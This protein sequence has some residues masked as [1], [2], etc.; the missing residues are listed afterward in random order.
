MPHD[1]QEFTP[2]ERAKLTGLY[3]WEFDPPVKIVTSNFVQESLWRLCEVRRPLSP[4]PFVFIESYLRVRGLFDHEEVGLAYRLLHE[5]KLIDT[6]EFHSLGEHVLLPRLEYLGLWRDNDRLMFVSL[7][8]DREWEWLDTCD[9]VEEFEAEY[10]PLHEY[11]KW[12]GIAD[13]RELCVRRF[14][15]IDLSD[16]TVQLRRRAIRLAKRLYSADLSKQ[17]M[18]TTTDTDPPEAKPI[19]PDK[20]ILNELE[21]F[22]IQT[23][24][25]DTLAG[26][27]IVDRPAPEDRVYKYNGQFKTALA[28][29]RRRKILDNKAPGYE[30]AEPYRY[31]VATEDKTKV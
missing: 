6:E 3:G 29:L 18:A 10:T 30:L 16:G 27:A 2:T 5:C 13:W 25:T 1:I 7:T 21:M 24:G 11:A 28:A 4:V 23:L 9:L 8:G 26:Q 31:L 19:T 12:K 15:E 20:P 14:T 22:I 17:A